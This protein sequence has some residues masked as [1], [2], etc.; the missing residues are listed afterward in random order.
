[1]AT[2]KSGNW[3]GLFVCA[4]RTIKV[5]LSLN[6]SRDGTVSG[7]FSFRDKKYSEDARVGEVHGTFAD[8]TLALQLG[9]QDAYASFHRQVHPAR[10]NRQDMLFALVPVY[11]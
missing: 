7:D 1:M 10:P 11:R 9:G 6:F 2:P 8:N 3:N 5:K 4:D